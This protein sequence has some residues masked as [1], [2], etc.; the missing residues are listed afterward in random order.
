M[1]A[2]YHLIWTVYGVWLPND[3]RGSGSTEIRSSLLEDLGEIYYGRKKIQPCSAV[4]RKFYQ[5]AKPK[6]KHDTIVFTDDEI[7]STG[8]IEGDAREVGNTALESECQH[9]R[10]CLAIDSVDDREDI[11]VCKI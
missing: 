9:Q 1:V 8:C 4:I 11:Q 10:R 7:E 6:L 3:P 2:A 5:E